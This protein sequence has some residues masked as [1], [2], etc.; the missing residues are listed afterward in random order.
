M[1]TDKRGKLSQPLHWL[2]HWR[3]QCVKH[4]GQ[5]GSIGL[6]PAPLL[7]SPLSRGWSTRTPGLCWSTSDP[8]SSIY[9]GRQS[10]VVGISWTERRRERWHG[11]H[12]MDLHIQQKQRSSLFW[13]QDRGRHFSLSLSLSHSL[14][15]NNH[16]KRNK[17]KQDF[18]SFFLSFC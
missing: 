12:Q 1:C 17:W 8:L 7:L 9:L 16:Y 2:Y 11:D 3:G 18:L 15:E 10:D 14:R 13:S 4:M 5:G 6:R